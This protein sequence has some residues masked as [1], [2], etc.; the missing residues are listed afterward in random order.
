MEKLIRAINEYGKTA[1]CWPF[2]FCRLESATDYNSSY[3]VLKWDDNWEWDWKDWFLEVP[4][5]ISKEYW[6]IERLYKKDKL[7]LYKEKFLE[8][9][10]WSNNY[11]EC[12]YLELIQWLAI[13]DTPIDDLLYYLK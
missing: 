6:F 7:N 2:E 9:P 11:D 10:I 12:D 13:S 1:K 8:Y 3:L 4:R 5:L